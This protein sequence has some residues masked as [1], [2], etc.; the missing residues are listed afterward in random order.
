MIF[1]ELN[2]LYLDNSCSLLLQF[3]HERNTTKLH[4]Q[5]FLRMNIWMFETRQSHYN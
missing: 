5:V 3:Q 4:V 2:I 1:Y